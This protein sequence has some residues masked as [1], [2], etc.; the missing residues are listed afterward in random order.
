MREALARFG[1][2]ISGRAREIRGR[3]NHDIRS[4]KKN[5][6]APDQA[7]RRLRFHQR[8]EGLDRRAYED[9]EE[10][11]PSPA[12]CAC[13]ADDAETDRRNPGRRLALL[14]DPRRN[15]RARENY[16]YRAVPGQGRNW[17]LQA[18]HATQGHCG[19]APANASV[20]GLALFD[21]RCSTCRS[22][23]GGCRDDR[24]DARADAARIA[25][26]RV[27]LVRRSGGSL[28]F[29]AGPVKRTKTTLESYVS[30][31]ADLTFAALLPRMPLPSA[32]LWC[33]T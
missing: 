10:K 2:D 27:A 17:T 1:F 6:A 33:D 13:D 7:R 12:P 32:G 9:R 21:G 16:R 19:V 26:S 11:G 28:H 23:Q 4:R 24:R 18:D 29:A 30:C 22:R 20:P 14:G 15:R 31:G 25:R 5:A 8:A 3:H